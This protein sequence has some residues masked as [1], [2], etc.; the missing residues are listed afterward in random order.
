MELKSFLL[1]IENHIAH[2]SFNRPDKANSLSEET[3][4][5]MKAVFDAVSDDPSVRVVILSGEGKHF[6]AGMDLMTL[7]GVQNHGIK[8]EARKRI[9]IRKF[10]RKIQD[11]IT[12]IE[13]CRKPVMAAVHGGCIGGGLNIVTACDMRYCTDDAYFTLKE[14]DLGIVADIGALQRMPDILHPGMVAELA[15]TGRNVDGME[16]KSIGL[17][18]ST[19]IDKATM[20]KE[21]LKIA[22]TIASKSPLVIEGIKENLVYRRDH[23][24]NDSLDYIAIYNSAML[25]SDDLAEAFQAY[26]AKRKP[27]FKS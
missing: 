15:Y 16:A 3:W 21:V 20:M 10:I 25:I 27:V 2:L 22:G 14:V 9:H 6:C 1:N 23:T 8:D 17:V 13:K 7:M 19:W 26:M 11:S 18:N 24:V 12:A 5:E 4:D